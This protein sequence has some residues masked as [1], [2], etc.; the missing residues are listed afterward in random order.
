MPG[1]RMHICWAGGG[2]NTPSFHFVFDLYRGDTSPECTA[3]APWHSRRKALLRKT[4]VHSSSPCFF[5]VNNV[6][7]TPRTS[8]NHTPGL[9]WIKF[10][11][12]S[13]PEMSD[14]FRMRGDAGYLLLHDHSRL[15]PDR[16]YGNT[17]RQKTLDVF[18]SNYY[19][20]KENLRIDLKTYSTP[21]TEERKLFFLTIQ[22]FDERE[23]LENW[24]LLYKI[25]L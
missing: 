5:D 16:K 1:I 6:E 8:Y 25:S 14:V 17:P 9:V 11:N 13:N 4:K 21:C 10:I 20:M 24:E 7:S 2:S 15:H 12:E 19:W 18:H 22:Q 23:T 3:L